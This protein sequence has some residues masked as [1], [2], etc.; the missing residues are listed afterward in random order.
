MFSL[1]IGVQASNQQLRAAFDMEGYHCRVTRTEPY[2]S[3]L[4]KQYWLQ[5]AKQR[6]FWTVQDWLKVLHK[7]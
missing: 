1:F 2:L 7:V 4:N 6:E 5:W 3:M